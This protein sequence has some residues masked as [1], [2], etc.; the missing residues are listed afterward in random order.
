MQQ[1]KFEALMLTQNLGELQAAPRKGTGKIEEN[2]D[3]GVTLTRGVEVPV[4]SKATIEFF[5]LF[6]E[7]G[8]FPLC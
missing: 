3:H 2:G 7:R 4:R 1:F 6:C 8:G 5:C